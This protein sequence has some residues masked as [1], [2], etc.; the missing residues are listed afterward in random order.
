[1]RY[2]DH[3]AALSSD[4]ICRYLL[5]RRWRETAPG[6]RGTVLWIMANRSTAD[7]RDDDPTVRK[8]VGFTYR[9]GWDAVAVANLWPYRATK[10]SWLSELIHHPYLDHAHYMSSQDYAITTSAARA[11][12]VLV[13]WGDCLRRLPEFPG[14]VAAVLNLLLSANAD[15]RCLGLTRHGNPCHPLMLPYATPLLP[16]LCSSASSAVSSAPAAPGPSPE[17]PP[18]APTT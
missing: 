17:Q 16:Y 6:G 4:D 8:V 10:P 13:A 2:I 12:R 14:R 7:G 9:W 18:S 3:D 1:M 11:G 15:I 5:Y